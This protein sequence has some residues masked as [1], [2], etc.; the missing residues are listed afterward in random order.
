MLNEFYLKFFILCEVTI[1]TTFGGTGWYLSTVL[2]GLNHPLAPKS[3]PQSSTGIMKIHG[4]GRLVGYDSFARI[5]FGDT[6]SKIITVFKHIV[7]RDL[8]IRFDPL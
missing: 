5:K 8:S 7:Q 1:A 4:S 3:T 6:E 2:P